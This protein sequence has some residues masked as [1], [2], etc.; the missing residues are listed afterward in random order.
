[1]RY[2][3]V[4][5]NP[6][7][8]VSLLRIRKN[9]SKTL[10]SSLLALSKELYEKGYRFV[11]DKYLLKEDLF[12]LNRSSGAESNFFVFIHAKKNDEI[13]VFFSNPSFSPNIPKDHFG[14]RI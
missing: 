9:L 13:E 14:I 5:E 8:A 12:I 3:D 1:M 6:E 11:A 4:Y 7:D 10:A 2:K